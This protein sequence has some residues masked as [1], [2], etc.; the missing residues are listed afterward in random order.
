MRLPPATRLAERTASNS[1]SL[2]QHQTP[3]PLP[4]LTH[5]ALKPGRST[6]CSLQCSLQW[7]SLQWP[8]AAMVAAMAGLAK[9]LRSGGCCCCCW[10]LVRS[11]AWLGCL[12]AARMSAGALLGRASCPM[13]GGSGSAAGSRQAIAVCRHRQVGSHTG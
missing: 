13:R 8:V 6:R 11:S 7:P 5:H 10:Q 1:I 2:L 4:N 9:A 12:A 3:L